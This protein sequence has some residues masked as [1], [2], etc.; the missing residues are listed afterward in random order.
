MKMEEKIGF[1]PD[2]SG[3]ERRQVEEY[4]ERHPH[5]GPVFEELRRLDR[6]LRAG[7]RI[8]ADPPSDDVL[9]F[10]AVMEDVDRGRMPEAM[11][12]VMRKV[13]GRID[14]DKELRSRYDRFKIRRRE[15]ETGADIEAQFNRLRG[16]HAGDIG[17]VGTVAKT[18]RR[19]GNGDS[20]TSGDRRD[21]RRAVA[22]VRNVRGGRVA[23][24]AFVAVT[25]YALLFV[26]GRI[27]RPETEQL[28]AFD[29][30][31][32]LLEGFDAVR[33]AAEEQAPVVSDDPVEAYLEAIE[34]LQTAETSFFGLFPHFDQE[35]LDRAAALLHRVLDLE[36]PETFLAGEA[37]FLLA[38]T[39]LA[40]GNIDAARE[41]LDQVSVKFG[42][43]SEAAE[44]LLVSIDALDE[45]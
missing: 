24:V 45:A 5:L 12:E 39:E 4:V 23:R 30:D 14:N 26:G 33:G 35:R 28:A 7:K 31:E 37:S 41:A 27:L 43:H 20:G 29:R 40:R 19:P 15:L 32:L 36:P 25:V 22:G 11:D 1:Y 3:D 13:M 34:V 9:A 38:K 17:G 21:D 2:L 42:R 10:V 18:P 8:E 16:G 44:R 6:A